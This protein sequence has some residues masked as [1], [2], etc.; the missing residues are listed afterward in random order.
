M[1]RSKRSSSCYSSHVIGALGV[2]LESGVM[3]LYVNEGSNAERRRRGVEREDDEDHQTM[4]T[5][6]SRGEALTCAIARHAG[7]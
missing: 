4:P 2:L 5:V 7:H 1:C 6:R 3:V